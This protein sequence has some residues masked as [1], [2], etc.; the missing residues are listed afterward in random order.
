MK[1]APGMNK[2]LGN[3]GF[4]VRRHVAFVRRRVALALA[5]LVGGAGAPGPAWAQERG[6]EWGWG[7]TRCGESGG[8]E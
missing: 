8:S 5:G 2:F 4:V 3:W 7:M 1:R 6:W